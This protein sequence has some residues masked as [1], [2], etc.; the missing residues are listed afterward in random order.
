MSQVNKALMGIRPALLASILKRTLRIQRRVVDTKVGRFYIDPVSNFGVGVQREQGYEPELS[1]AVRTLLREGD[2]FLDVGANEGFF[3]IVASKAVGSTGHVIAIEP[4]SRLQEVVARNIRE[5]DALNIDLIQ[6]AISDDHGVAALSLSP[7]MNTGSSGIFRAPR[8]GV[9]TQDVLQTT[10]DRLFKLL[11]LRSVRLMKIDIEG[12]E[13]EAVLGSCDVFRAGV[14][15]YLAL[16]RH[17]TILRRPG[18]AGAGYRRLPKRV[19]L[20]TRRAVRDVHIC[21]ID[22]HLRLAEVMAVIG[23]EAV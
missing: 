14:I 11:S 10:L 19:R 20:S 12:F 9:P 6:R 3:S 21:E 13:Y 7:E 5:N 1:H 16:E 22:V 23:G 17:P 2:I 15:E 4:Q 18:Q 8:Y